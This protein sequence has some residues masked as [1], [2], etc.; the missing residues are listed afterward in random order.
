MVPHQVANQGEEIAGDSPAQDNTEKVV[1]QSLLVKEKQGRHF[2][3]CP[4]LFIPFLPNKGHQQDV[5][6]VEPEQQSL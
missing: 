1:S 6:R 3:A 5:F 4:V 2:G